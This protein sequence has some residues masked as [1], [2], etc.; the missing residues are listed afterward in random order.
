MGE[1]NHGT[2]I[3]ASGYGDVIAMATLKKH[4]NGNQYRLLYG[5]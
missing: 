1:H 5:W 4:P 2:I 3:N